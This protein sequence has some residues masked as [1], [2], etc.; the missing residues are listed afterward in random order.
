MIITYKDGIY[1]LPHEL[2][3]GLIS[4]Y[5]GGQNYVLQKL[6]KLENRTR[7]NNLNRD[8]LNTKKDQTWEMCERKVKD[9]S[10][11]IIEIKKYIFIKAAHKTKRKTT[12]NNSTEK[13]TAKNSR[14]KT[15]QL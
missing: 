3:N 8:E 11:E 2:P 13:S 9:I 7:R 14:T 4:E 1:E 6:T 12:R 15:C 10:Q 5:Q